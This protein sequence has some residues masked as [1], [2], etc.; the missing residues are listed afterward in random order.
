MTQETPPETNEKEGIPKR[1]PILPVR[2][3]VLYPGLV[4]PLQV[5]RGESVKLVDDVVVSNAPLVLVAQRDGDVENPGPNDLFDVGTLGTVIK[6]MKQPDGSYHIIVR[7]TH[8]VRLSEFGK[9][10]RYHDARIEVV[11]EDETTDSEVEAMALNLRNQFER[12]IELTNLP[13]E[14][15]VIALNVERPIQLVYIVSANLNLTVKEKQTLLE[16]PDVRT[17]LDRITFYLTRQLERLELAQKIQSRVKAGMDKRQREFFLREQ[18]DVI[19]RELGE[20]EEKN[21]DVQ[22]LR[23]RIEALDLPDEART[24]AEKELDRLK[25]MSPAS[26]E[27]SVSRN[28]LDWLLEVPWNVTTEDSLDV[29]QAA[30]ILDEDHYDLEKVKRRILEY[31]A[32][33]QLKKDIKGP[34]L[35]FVGPPGVG[36]TS[37]GQSIARSLNR[38]FIRISLGGM[39]DEA[40]IRGHRRTYVGALPGR[41]IQGLRRIGSRNPVF[42]LDE[43]DKLGADFR[44]DPSSALLEVLDPE[45][46]FAFSDHYLEVP[47][48]LSKVIFVATANV[49]DPI[50]S[51]LRDRM[52]VIDIPGYTEE[53]KLQIARKYL[54]ARQVEN[55]G[56]SEGQVIIPDE[57][58]LEMIR[59]YT[60]EAGVRNL[61]R[62]LA[63]V[64]RHTARE[65]AEGTE[66]PI[67]IEAKQL[68]D[69]LGPVR[70]I[71]ESSTRS[72]GAGISTG[73]AWTPVGGELIFIEA[74]KIKGHGK[75]T[76]T[77]QLGDVMKESATAALTYIRAHSEELNIEAKDVLEWDIHV[78]VPA[79]GI[80]KDGPSA[81]VALVVALASLM[82][83][84]PVRRNVAMTGEI[85]LRGDVLPVGG[86]KEKIL[87]ARRAGIREVLIP[88]A[89]ERD[90]VDIAPHLRE[91]MTFHK[92]QLIS[93]AI[94]LALE[95]SGAPAG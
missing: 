6:L 48:D 4:L 69:I 28:Y 79:G 40:E 20:G 75:L 88:H 26:A 41:I 95:S 13:A 8:K 59:S 70:Y 15:N 10:D 42:M 12:F 44:G 24:A 57:A 91:G 81:G 17:A 30:A 46:N 23:I 80:P 58:I 66:G 74:L 73:L 86:I 87:A 76:L 29:K 67:I 92:L 34:I 35:C 83:G 31:L 14:L 33:L 77:G 11:A 3:T 9:P 45:Q 5:E 84:I 27:Y 63:A 54:V 85:T 52:E 49:M 55:H 19:R 36:K 78:H 32:V 16:L 61:D 68:P 94:Q 65:I 25:R 64:C 2:N 60:R 1:A 37:L 50:P 82:S 56:L 18:M 47:F 72:W 21:P 89:N 62:T 93:E 38:K 90:L 7:G 53:E 71:P 39:R 22:E 51:A 43:I